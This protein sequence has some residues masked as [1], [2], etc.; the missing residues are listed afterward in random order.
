[1]PNSKLFMI[2][3]S[4]DSHV[5]TDVALMYGP[6]SIKHGWMQEGVFIFWGPAQKT[7]LDDSVVGLKVKELI[8]KEK[9][10][11]W[12]CKACSDMYGVSKK[13]ED[14]GI[15]V[16]YVGEDVSNMIKQGWHCLTF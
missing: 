6:N 14:L 11:V 16:K 12:A 13:L 1:M 10:Q 9:V 7:I 3:T 2:I 5:I 15:T 8:G 4:A